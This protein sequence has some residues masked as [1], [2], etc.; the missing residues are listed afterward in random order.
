MLFLEASQPELSV[1][2]TGLINRSN[3]LKPQH[4]ESNILQQPEAL[5]QNKFDLVIIISGSLSFKR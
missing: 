5:C 1:T 4:F 3:I 2:L